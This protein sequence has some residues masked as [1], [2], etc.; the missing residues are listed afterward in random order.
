MSSRPVAP[1]RIVGRYRIYDPI[2]SGGMATVHLGKLDGSVG[3]S[4]TVA[5]K[6][7][8]PHLATDKAFV[9]MFVDE[10]LLA[11]RIRHP[12][13]VATLDVVA[14]GK[15]IFLVL[16]YVEGESLAR[17][18]HAAFMEDK[19]PPPKVIVAVA[20]DVLHGLHAAHE[21][22]DESG[23]P[24]GIVHRDVSPQNILVAVDGTAR[25][26]D[27]GVAK[28]RRRLQTTQDGSLKGKIAYM[29]PEQIGGEATR[30]SDVFAVGVVLWEGLA[31]RRLFHSENEA[32][33][34]ALV[35][36]HDVAPPSTVARLPL[37]SPAREALDVIVLRAVAKDPKQ[38]FGSALEMAVALEQA[39]LAATR[40]EVS[41]WLR[42]SASKALE[43]RSRQ[44][45]NLESD[46]T[47]LPT[48]PAAPPGPSSPPKTPKRGA[49]FA[50][51][52]ELSAGPVVAP[53]RSRRPV[54]AALAFLGVVAIALVSAVASRRTEHSS[55]KA[56]A[57]ALPP[58]SDCSIMT[59]CGL[60][61]TAS[62]D[63]KAAYQAGLQSLRDASF[64]TARTNFDHATGFD[65]GLA[66]AHLRLAISST[67]FASESD[68]RRMFARAEALRTSLS[69][70]DKGILHAFE[71]YFHSDMGDVA[72]CAKRLEA[73]SKAAP[74][75][76]EIAFYLGFLRFQQGQLEPAV[77]A[78]DHAL[79]LDPDLG[80]AWSERGGA[81]AFLGRFDEAIRSLDHCIQT[82]P[83]A[84]DCIWYRAAID[85]QMG[86]CADVE[87][88]AKRAISKEPDNYFGYSLLANALVSL[89]RSDDAVEAA[90]EAKWKNS[91]PK[92]RPRVEL[93]DR[94]NRDMLAGRFADAERDAQKLEALAAGGDPSN[95]SHALPAWALVQI[96][97]ETGRP[98]LARDAARRF[99]EREGAWTAPY[100]VDDVALARDVV[101]RMLLTL[102]H[103]GAMTADE[104]S[105][106]RDQ[107]LD[108]WK[109]RTSGVY[110]HHLWL[111]GYAA[112]AETH[113]D[114]DRALEALPGFLPLPVFTPQ[115][116]TS[117]YLGKVYERAGRFHE[118]EAPLRAT[119]ASCTALRY[120]IDQTRAF[121]DL[122][123]A[124]EVE[125]PTA[126]CEAYSI[127]VARWGAAKP[128]SV[129]AGQA[130]RRMDALHC[131]PSSS[132]AGPR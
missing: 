79:E 14:D 36:S 74:R 25:V 102:L 51:A 5:I 15:E 95:Y 65:P 64:S 39:G 103:T 77:A 57:L 117:A 23:E 28:A 61:S 84:T 88:D 60:P 75:D 92:S 37:P 7:L 62:P 101:P 45:K 54:R 68:T 80:S 50:P 34:M 122:G 116:V 121:L 129:S 27:F 110:V 26:L 6:R 98:A 12:N 16:D 96:Y 3:F 76:S 18:L 86:R 59:T 85:E 10:A 69:E 120:P 132:K 118:A 9:D 81:L 71:P 123:T 4:R 1:V 63:A 53:S 32:R 111:Y 127:V 2:G 94:L 106:R 109:R 99:L 126:A 66:A 128:K 20:C 22:Q 13:V 100:R 89:G 47:L 82:S 24:L 21:A 49:T 93:H 70:R 131:L 119:T 91:P 87:A 40:A 73:A 17:L 113:G 58:E 46:V 108:S 112:G 83:L 43:E 29:A 8:H 115:S 33:L 38:R 125:D 105:A 48:R 72:E 124:L 30:Q 104:L 19:P 42:D 107:W 52:E 35:M 56:E 31:V 114:A 97:L 55:P 130:R 90:L 67:M 78:L 44:V 41:A 11:T